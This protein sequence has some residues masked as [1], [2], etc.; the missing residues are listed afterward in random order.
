MK[1]LKDKRYLEPA[2]WEAKNKAA[3]EAF[4]ARLA[5]LPVAEAKAICLRFQA[6][7]GMAAT[8]SG[9]IAAAYLAKNRT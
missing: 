9:R 3:D 5:S 8:S 2:Q 1:E 4:K 7:T 6:D